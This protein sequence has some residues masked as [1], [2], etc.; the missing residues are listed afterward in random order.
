MYITKFV[1]NH[2]YFTFEGIV[3]L[4]AHRIEEFELVLA[5]PSGKNWKNKTV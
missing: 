2:C 5:L 3:D 4:L 1:T